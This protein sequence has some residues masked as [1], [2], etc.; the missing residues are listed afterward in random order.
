METIRVTINDKQY[1]L[2][3]AKTEEEKEKGLQEVEEMDDNEGMFFDYRDNPENELT[4]WMKDTLIPL[5]ILFISED[6]EVI[7]VSKGEPESEDFLTCMPAD[8]TIVAVIELN[9]NSGVQEGDEIDI[10]GEAL[11]DFP[12]NSMFVL[13]SDGTIQFELQ[14]GERIF[15]RVSSRNIIRKAKKAYNSKSDSDYKALGKYIFKEL[16]AQDKRKPEYVEK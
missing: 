3:W 11:T 15:S 6:F 9:Q 2:L 10:E 5:D 14:G 7:Q 1:N 16:D 4:F 12:A 8:T 13:N